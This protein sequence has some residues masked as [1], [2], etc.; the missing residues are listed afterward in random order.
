MLQVLQS[1]RD[2][3]TT[4]AEVPTPVAGA[5]SL[6]VRTVA[7]V[8]SAG[9]ERMLVDFGRSSWIDKARS[10]PDKVRQVLDKMRTDGIGPTLDSVRA[11]LDQPLVLGYCQAGVVVE[12][13]RGV[14]GFAPGDHVVT[15]G[16]HAEFVRVAPTLAA[17]IPE[18][19]SFEHAAFTPLAAIAL[20]GIRLAAPTLGETVVVYGL[21]LIGQLA[22]Q[23]CRAAGCRVVGIDRSPERVGLAR[24]AGALGVEAGD[25]VDV[26][27]A[28]LTHTGGVGADAVLLTLAADSDEPVHHA[29]TMSRKR[30]RIVL[31]GVTGLALRRDDFYR[32]ELSLQ[33]SCSYGPGRYDAEHEERGIDYPLPFVRW[34]E[35]RNFDAVLHLMSDGRVS[36]AS[37]VSHRLPVSKAEQ[38][39]DL[40]AS[41]QGGLGIVLEYPEREGAAARMISVAAATGNAPVTE[42]ARVGML[43]AGG[44][45][46]KVLVP[47]L[48]AAG[49]QLELI[50][51][52]A[53]VNA[54]TAA[55]QHGFARATTDA[56]ALCADPAVDFVVVAT[57][58]DSHAQWVKAALAAG[59]HVFVEKPLA[60]REED[61][62][63]I[64]E[65]ALAAGRMVCVGFNRRMARD[66][67]ALHDVLSRRA[68]PVHLTLTMN[69]GALP[70]DHWT[71][72]PEVGG[73]RIVGEACHFID[74]ARMLVGAPIESAAVAVARR[75]GLVMDD[76][77]TITLTHSDG[78][79][80]VVNYLANGA[81]DYPKERVDAFFDGKV[82]RL[83][84]LRRVQTWGADV[85][86]PT[87]LQG[88]DKG[89]AAFLGAFVA[90]VRR[91]AQPPV[92]LEEVLEVSRWS[93]RIAR[94]ARFGGGLVHA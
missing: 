89:H 18:G 46:G 62:D 91:G 49:A 67:R 3:A 66:V 28:V 6:L 21:G 84:N 78:S 13:G 26:A 71:L 39:Y 50:A 65:A 42:R 38:A 79:V 15:N 20:Q 55:S 11:K 70:P 85:G 37:L 22:V 34:T 92:A 72:D 88:Q 68:G 4:V 5:Q 63:A 53:G 43:G 12:V 69:A 51:S 75:G 40:V 76:V 36:P 58:H 52:S 27:A 82:V 54:A 16:P 33:V 1:L 25:G 60:L 83:D 23:L 87:L 44:F 32:K 10:Q 77:A 14:Q 93:I 47:A 19:V 35:G 30:G 31:V 73:G 57:R 56:A 41:G 80:A 7:T 64:G 9:T 86:K 59:K 17:R 29:A 24:E 90:A 2:G 94:C 8:I 61:V 81:R 74:L 48:K 45:G